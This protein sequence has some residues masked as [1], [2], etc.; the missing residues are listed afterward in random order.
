MKKSICNTLIKNL[1]YQARFFYA[2]FFLFCFL[3]SCTGANKKTKKDD[4][5]IVKIDGHKLTL[6]QFLTKSQSSPSRLFNYKYQKGI[7]E[8][9]KKRI[10]KQFLESY[11]LKKW[12]KKNNISIPSSK[13]L[14]YTK[15]LMSG[16]E[17]PISFKQSLY[18]NN[19]SKKQLAAFIRA[20]LLREAW[21]KLHAG[22]ISITKKEAKL[23]LKN[24]KEFLKPV[25]IATLRHILLKT[26]TD[27]EI[28]HNFLTKNKIKFSDIYSLL[29][30]FNPI[31]SQKKIH[32]PYG[33][34]NI[35]DP[36]FKMNIGEISPVT[37]S[38]WGWHIYQVLKLEKNKKSLSKSN[39][40]IKS[41]LVEKKIDSL[42][43]GWIQ[44]QL[45]N[46]TVL[47]NKSILKQL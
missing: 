4:I 9:T 19:V 13:V 22:K 36:A 16:Y 3:I 10:I 5:T 35:F 47:I 6:K 30:K 1:A 23:F 7:T 27:A 2:I 8:F 42:Y 25:K 18:E 15:K 39:S 40:F 26:E 21:I 43:Q 20:K 41:I 45:K 29:P 32:V 28:I 44:K 17:G 12:A 38:H 11:L 31:L 14:K 46:K 24:K 37:Q 34:S 33:S